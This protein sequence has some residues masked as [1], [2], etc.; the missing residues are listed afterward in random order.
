MASCNIKYLQKKLG[1]THTLLV[2]ER[3]FGLPLGLANVDSRQKEEQGIG[4]LFWH[5]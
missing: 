5:I 4:C 1:R 3:V 2:L